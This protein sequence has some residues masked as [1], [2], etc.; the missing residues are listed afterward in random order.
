MNINPK[1]FAGKTVDR[2]DD[3]SLNQVIFFFTDGTTATLE[4][5]AVMPT[6]GL[7]G[8]TEVSK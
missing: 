4:V 2:I 7:Y 8:I 1:T 5:E 3:T 6:Y